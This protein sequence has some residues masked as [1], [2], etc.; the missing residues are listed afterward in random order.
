MNTLSNADGRRGLYAQD[1][2]GVLFGSRNK[3]GY[4]FVEHVEKSFLLRQ[5]R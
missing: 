2:R 5:G 4:G 3:G 1:V